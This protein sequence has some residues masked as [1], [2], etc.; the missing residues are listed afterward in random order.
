[1][2]RLIEG[3]GVLLLL[4][5]FFAYML[6]PVVPPVRRRVRIGRRRRPISDGS[7]ILLLYLAIFVPGALLWRMTEPAVRHWVAVTAPAG[8]D[9][10][11]AGGTIAPL[12]GL[13]THAP[14]PAAVRATMMGGS[15]RLAAA[16]ER[17]TR[18]TL[19]ELI[20]AA[21]YAAWLAVAPIVAFLL[22]T[23][24]P[25]FQRSA[26]RVLPRGHLQWRLEE[27]L[28]DVNSALA[29][30]VR[31]QAGAAVIVGAACVAGF[32]LIGVPSAISLGVLA[33][34]LELVP[35]IG[36]L[37]VLLIATSQGDRVVAIVLFL[38]ALRVVQDYVVYPR[39]IRHGMHLSTLAVILTVWA[40]AVLAGAAGVI[41][42]IPAAGFL[43]VSMRHWRE[44]REIERLIREREIEPLN[45]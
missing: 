19:A 16:L 13:L 28:R 29:G 23:G 24:A 44:Y 21:R 4:S 31:A 20:T 15:G 39:L 14:L 7:A 42:A 12:D 25:A 38:A 33:G 34:I 43:S 40:G 45:P 36:P 30:Y 1:M 10:L 3:A 6:A 35:A 5:V 27:Y 17:S 26:L 41:I 22:L 18:A 8:V 37:T 9:R 2:L 32:A 11:F